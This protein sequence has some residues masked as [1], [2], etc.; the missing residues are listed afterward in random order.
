[1]EHIAQALTITLAIA[2]VA[3]LLLKT[4][5]D[6]EWLMRLGVSR[7]P[8]F[9]QG[10]ESEREIQRLPLLQYLRFGTTGDTAKDARI[11]RLAQLNRIF[12]LI[13]VAYVIGVL[14]FVFV[15]ILLS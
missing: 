2:I 4:I 1:V 15:K 6:P 14:V 10:P 13:F 7:I 12:A 3:P 11:R 5:R 8:L 9:K